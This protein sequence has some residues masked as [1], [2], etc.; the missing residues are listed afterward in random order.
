M[1]GMKKI[2]ILLCFGLPL[3]FL[4][5]FGISLKAQTCEQ[6]LTDARKAAD[7]GAYKDA[8][9][10][11]LAAQK[12]CPTTRDQEIKGYVLDVFTKIEA[13]KKKAE[14]AEETAKKAL[15][16]AETDRKKAFKAEKDAIKALADVRAANAKNV[17]LILK[18]AD[19][20]IKLLKYDE[21]LEKCQV[22]L[23]LGTEGAEQDSI[24]RRVLEIAYF[25]TETDTAEAAIK[26][27]NL[28]KQTGFN[29]NTPDIR[30]NLQ[31]EI[32][33]LCL[34]LGT[35]SEQYFN[36]LNERYYPKMIFVEGGS[37]HWRYTYDKDN[38]V[39]DSAFIKVNSFSMAETETTVWQY[40]LFQKATKHKEPSTPSWQWK[41]DNPI[42]NVSWYDVVEYTNW[43]SQKQNRAQVYDIDKENQD[44]VTNLSD[45]DDVKWTVN[46]NF[47]AKGYRLPTEAEWEYAARGGNRS[48]G[49][50]YSGSND[51]NEVAWYN[52]NSKNQTHPVKGKKANELGLFDMSGNVW[53]WC[54]D[55]YGDYD[56]S[57]KENP[58]GAEKGSS[59]VVRGGS[60]LDDDNI[61]RVSN[62]SYD[63]PHDYYSYFV[64][65]CVRYD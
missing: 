3:P 25:Y 61:C 24:K 27:L 37:N 54:N 57:Q 42:V 8:V 60:W 50:E 14:D 62:R 63:Y 40:F 39:K 52:F 13:L 9:L 32:R 11:Y 49:F 55:W 6:I 28:I 56:I 2:I 10:K 64:F 43:L 59:R 17:L 20:N 29:A 18:E 26:T 12:V 5:G 4:T 23:A 36:A 46:A 58:C 45:Y 31:S 33:N 19:D 53:E 41:G 1:N 30:R 44:T 51:I 35:P 21:A 7:K 38:K 48:K 22:A 47:V 16:Q 15:K 34:A 65:R